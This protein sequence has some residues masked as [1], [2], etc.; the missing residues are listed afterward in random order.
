MSW[1]PTPSDTVDAD[2]VGAKRLR[3][4]ALLAGKQQTDAVVVGRCLDEG[5]VITVIGGELQR[6]DVLLRDEAVG[7]ARE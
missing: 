4:P 6:I 2:P 5:G 3:E 1:L 7:L